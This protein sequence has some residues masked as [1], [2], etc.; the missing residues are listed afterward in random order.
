MTTENQ[1]IVET[2]A[3]KMFRTII[4]N[5]RGKEVQAI[6]LALAMAF[7]VSVKSSRNPNLAEALEVFV[8]QAKDFYHQHK[9][10]GRTYQKDVQ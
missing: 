8:K 10:I 4:E 9:K 2:D 7:A 6:R 5:M 1:E 3:L